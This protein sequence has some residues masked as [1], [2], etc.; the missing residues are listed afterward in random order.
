[1]KI[2]KELQEN[3]VRQNT[4]LLVDIYK[5]ICRIEAS[6]FRDTT[7]K[8]SA[9][10][11]IEV[12]IG[13]LRSAT[14]Q[15]REAVSSL[16]LEQRAHGAIYDEEI[17]Q[18]EANI[19]MIGAMDRMLDAKLTWFYGYLVKQSSANL[20]PAEAEDLDSLK[21]QVRRSQS[22]LAE[23]ADNASTCLGTIGSA[24]GTIHSLDNQQWSQWMVPAAK[25][26]SGY[27]SLIDNTKVLVQTTPKLFNSIDRYLSQTGTKGP[28][29]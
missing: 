12:D 4:D 17:K 8:K 24:L 2:N 15:N 28:F 13:K 19:V 14:S 27:G 5:R 7:T 10:E 21:Q 6:V 3:Y 22:G 1:M 25:H 11:N 18:A 16:T 9:I 20:S 26:L 29:M 23:V